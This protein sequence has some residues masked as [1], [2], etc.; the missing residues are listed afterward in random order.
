MPGT[1]PVLLACEQELA[2]PLVRDEAAGV[3]CSGQSPRSGPQLGSPARRVRGEVVPVCERPQVCLW[4]AACH[5][6]GA[7]PRQASGTPHGF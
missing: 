5:R 1:R 4:K 2:T 3:G 7:P 6:R